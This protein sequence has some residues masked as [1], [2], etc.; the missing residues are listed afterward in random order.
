MN[1]TR[2]ARLTGGDTL[3]T[4]PRRLVGAEYKPTQKEQ[5][6]DMFPQSHILQVWYPMNVRGNLAYRSDFVAELK[7]KKYNN[8]VRFSSA[9]SSAFRLS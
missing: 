1:R 5:N 2:V 7:I 3:I 4:Q 9:Y 8:S 6:L